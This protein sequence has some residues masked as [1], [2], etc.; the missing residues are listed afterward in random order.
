MRWSDPM[1]MSAFGKNPSRGI[2]DTHGF[3]ADSRQKSGDQ[4]VTRDFM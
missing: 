1:E 2:T 3:A 4:G